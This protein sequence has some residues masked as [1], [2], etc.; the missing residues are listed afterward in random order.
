VKNPGSQN[1]NEYFVSPI[2]KKEEEEEE[3]EV[4]FF[5]TST[6]LLGLYI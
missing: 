3:R 2:C 6:K 4:F 1:C 5:S